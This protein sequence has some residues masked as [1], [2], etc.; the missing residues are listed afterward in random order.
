[1]TLATPTREQRRSRRKRPVRAASIN[2]DRLPKRE[3]ARGLVLYPETHDWK[4]R[5]RGDC[6]DAVRPCPY[7]SCKHNLYLDVATSNGTI[8][9]N[10]PDIEPSEM[11]ESC[12][13]D[14]ADR[15]GK[16]LEEVGTYLNVTRERIR[17]IEVAA[18]SKLYGSPLREQVDGE[19]RVPCR[20]LEVSA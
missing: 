8:K 15:G 11:G 14:V 10:F 17:Q 2:C 1:M 16:P 13:L 9:L 7:V 18:F 20:V 4:P 3:L 12:A 19:T 6:A 5:T